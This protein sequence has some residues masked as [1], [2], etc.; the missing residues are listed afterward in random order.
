MG[1]ICLSV[2]LSVHLRGCGH[3]CLKFLRLKAE[4]C[5]KWQPH[6]RNRACIKG[7]FMTLPFKRTVWGV[8]STHTGRGRLWM[9]SSAQ[10]KS[11]TEDG[12]ERGG[13]HKRQREEN[14]QKPFDIFNQR[15]ML[16][17]L[18][19]HFQLGAKSSTWGCHSL[20]G[21]RTSSPAVV[22][23]RSHQFARVFLGHTPSSHM[24]GISSEDR[25]CH[26]VIYSEVLTDG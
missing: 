16:T 2:R 12:R 26:F 15:A 14:P 21:Q 4:H 5:T 8:Q 1:S 23:D 25:K 18:T 13:A 6:Q 19:L 17:C 11:E 22:F 3:A 10:T 9:E 7:L 24:P 20:H